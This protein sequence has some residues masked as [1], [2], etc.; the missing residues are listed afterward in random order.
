MF[1]NTQLSDPDSSH[2]GFVWVRRP[3]RPRI[4]RRR[5]SC[6]A[7]PSWN[8]GCPSRCC[9]ASSRGALEWS[10]GVQQRSQSPLEVESCSIWCWKCVLLIWA[11]KPSNSWTISSCYRVAKHVLPLPQQAFHFVDTEKAVYLEEEQADLLGWKFKFLT[12]QAGLPGLQW[13]ADP[14]VWIACTLVLI[15]FQI[16]PKCQCGP[17]FLELWISTVLCNDNWCLMSG[18]GHV[19]SG[20]GSLWS[21]SIKMIFEV[22]SGKLMQYMDIYG[23]KVTCHI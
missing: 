14:A 13:P 16:P 9:A 17:M 6:S 1:S 15:Q 12:I 3:T 22:G 5:D 23:I 4:A 18:S 2:V 8:A 19:W 21:S 10:L 11:W 7:R 20:Y